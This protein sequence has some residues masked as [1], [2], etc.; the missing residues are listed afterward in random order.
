METDLNVI[1][2]D[3]LDTDDDFERKDAEQGR[4]VGRARRRV[5]QP[6]P[7]KREAPRRP[8]VA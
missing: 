6:R 7:A 5:R 1:A 8:H 3:F 4:K 2:F